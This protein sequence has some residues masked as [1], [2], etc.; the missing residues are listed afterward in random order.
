MATITGF[1]KGLREHGSG[2]KFTFNFHNPLQSEGVMTCYE[3]DK[4]TDVARHATEAVSGPADATFPGTGVPRAAVTV[5]GH[6]GTAGTVIAQ[7]R[8]P[9]WGALGL[10]QTYDVETAP[11]AISRDWFTFKDNVP[12]RNGA[13]VVVLPA[14]R[15]ITIP[16]MNIEFAIFSLG[17]PA[18]YS[19]YLPKMNFINSN[20]LSLAGVLVFE[21][22]LLRFNGVRL[23]FR[24]LSSGPL[25]IARFSF[26]YDPTGWLTQMIDPPDFAG[27][28]TQS[29]IKEAPGL[30]QTNFPALL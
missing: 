11:V 14:A 3:P 28:L 15:P 5:I 6:A 27:P 23:T 4:I 17:I 20:T 29:Q 16:G 2:T 9:R 25:S 22:K 21:P 12:T 24:R 7:Y 10:L 26:T 19:Q 18:S 8:Y 1:Q 13:G 30:S